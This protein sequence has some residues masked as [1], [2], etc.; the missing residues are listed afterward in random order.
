METEDCCICLEVLGDSG[1]IRFK[2]KHTIHGGCFAEILK[3]SANPRCPECRLFLI[4]FNGLNRIVIDID[5]DDSESDI[6]FEDDGV[7][8][9][10]PDN[11]PELFF[12]IELY[13]SIEVKA[14]IFG[15]FLYTLIVLL[16]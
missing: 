4:E 6:A 10:I 14:I 13:K 2:C 5:D 8:V 1:T 12:K 3:I 9:D 16:I 15:I 11:E 7:V